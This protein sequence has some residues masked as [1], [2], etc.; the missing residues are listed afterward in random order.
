MEAGLACRKHA[1][2]IHAGRL[3]NRNFLTLIG[4][5]LGFFAVFVWLA[6]T[7]RRRAAPPPI[8]NHG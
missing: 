6:F 8:A 4:A 3:V 7:A 5:T 1:G 2:Q